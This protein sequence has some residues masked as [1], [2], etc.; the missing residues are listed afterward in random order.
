MTRW[1]AVLASVALVLAGTGCGHGGTKSDSASPPRHSTPKTVATVPSA[2]PAGTPSRVPEPPTTT[3]TLISF[4][5][6]GTRDDGPAPGEVTRP[7]A[8]EPFLIGPPAQMQK[9]RSA[10]DGGRRAGIRMFA[11]AL[12]GCQNTG[13]SLVI[14]TDRMSA[15]LTGGEGVECFAAQE[16]LAVF[17]VPANMVPSPLRLGR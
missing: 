11:F 2:S 13:A 7:G 1:W 17:A 8:I 16:F 14:G 5:L 9:V 6:L 4:V 3:P 12:P 15:R 10:V